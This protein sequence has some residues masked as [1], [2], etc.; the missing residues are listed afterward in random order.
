MM[1]RWQLHQQAAASQFC[2]QRKSAAVL[3]PLQLLSTFRAAAPPVP[4]LVAV[5]GLGPRMGPI[6]ASLTFVGTSAGNISC[7]TLY[8][9]TLTRLSVLPIEFAA[10]RPQLDVKATLQQKEANMC[11]T[12][13][14]TDL[15]WR[16]ICTCK[17]C[18]PSPSTLSAAMS[19]C[20]G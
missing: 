8:T 10:Q 19:A 4:A 1:G 7:C 11:K 5:R 15:R 3:W 18:K 14:L 13:T 16:A 9:S 6:A 17:F 2:R 12:P 20:N